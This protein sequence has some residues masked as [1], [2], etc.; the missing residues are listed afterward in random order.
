MLR[1]GAAVRG[2]KIEEVGIIFELCGAG[3]GGV[4]VMRYGYGVVRSMGRGFYHAFSPNSLS[5]GDNIQVL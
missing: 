3:G 5:H 4:L 2:G 1:S